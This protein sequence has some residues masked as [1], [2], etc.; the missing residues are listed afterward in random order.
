M[1]HRSALLATQCREI[2][3][4]VTTLPHPPHPQCD[5]VLSRLTE[6]QEKYKASQKEM[7]QLQMQQCELLENQR[8]MQEEQGQLQE[9]LHRLTF[10]LPKSGLFHKVTTARGWLLTMEK[11]L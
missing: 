2:P 10:P 9:E 4:R 11:L 7:G 3:Y 1:N 5:T 6:L 8:R